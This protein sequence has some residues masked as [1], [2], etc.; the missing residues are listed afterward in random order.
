MVSTLTAVSAILIAACG[1]PEGNADEGARWYIMHNCSACHGS[2]ANNG[3]ATEIA[4][5]D[6][7]FGSFVR[8]LRNPDSPSMP[9]FPESKLPEDDA[10]DIFAWLKNIP[11]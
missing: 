7:G 4:Q 8:Y 11:K 2:T 6:L 10:A 3:R 9:P 1:G 5:T